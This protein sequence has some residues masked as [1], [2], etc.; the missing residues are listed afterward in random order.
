MT[1]P[2]TI[3]NGARNIIEAR[4]LCKVFHAGEVEVEALRGVNL[5]VPSGEFI[6]I[7]G[8]SGSGKSTLF[9]I[10]GGLTPPTSGARSGYGSVQLNGTFSTLTIGVGAV[11]PG[12][13]NGSFTLS[14]VP[15][16]GSLM[17]AGVG[18]LSMV[19]FARRRRR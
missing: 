6:S 11:G 7:V 12:T 2:A 16:P 17:L 5:S 4:N 1:N 9:H 13:D 14:I 3:P 8:P 19:G 15:E 18:A 10:L